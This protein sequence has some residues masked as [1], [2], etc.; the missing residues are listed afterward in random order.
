MLRGINVGGHNKLPMAGLRV[1]CEA[2][3]PQ[4]LP[5]TYIASGN[6]I[7]ERP[8]GD[9]PLAAD[10]GA[11]IKRVFGLDVPVLLIEEDAFRKVVAACPFDPEAGKF[12]HG[13]FCFEVPVVD[14]AKRD[15]LIREC[16]ELVQDQ[17]MLWLHTPLGFSKS[18][19]AE[20][21]GQVTGH[22]SATARNLNSL[23]K[24][25]EMLDA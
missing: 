2:V 6:L 1:L 18:K 5:R 19:L 16:E 15:G 21:I 3:W 14:T 7:F 22:V 12:V 4:C 10:L 9:V 13:Y 25:V 20:R 24:L 17:I 8:T 23:R 11:A